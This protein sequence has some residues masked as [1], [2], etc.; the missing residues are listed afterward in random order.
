MV[1]LAKSGDRK[2]IELLFK[3]FKPI[4]YSKIKSTTYVDLSHEEME[5]EVLVFLTRILTRDI[6]K[7]DKT[8]ATFGSWMT[9]CFNNHILGIPHR[10]K[11]VNLDSIDD[12]SISKDGDWVEYPIKDESFSVERLTGIPFITIV[13]MLYEHLDE[14]QVRLIVEKYWYGSSSKDAEKKAGVP[15]GTCAQRIKRALKVINK[16][17]NK[18]DYI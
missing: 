6:D 1:V 17:I 9:A 10:K 16:H 5:D 12:M 18:N 2:A 15:H 11:R 3:K 4:L 14:T 7:F 13:R 8:K